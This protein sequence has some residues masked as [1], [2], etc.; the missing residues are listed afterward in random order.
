[1]LFTDIERSTQML[2][3]LGNE[4]YGL[5]LADHRR[6]CREAFERFGG[7]EVDTQG[8]SFFVVFE[9]AVDAAAAA[10]HAQAALGV[11]A[12]RVR[13]GLHTGNPVVSD[14]MYVG[15]DVHRAARIAAAAHGC[16]IVVSAAS[17]AELAGDPRL[18]SLGMHSLKDF[19]EPIEL[20]QLGPGD[21]PPLRSIAPTNLPTPVSAFIGRELEL[22]DAE[23]IRQTSRLLTIVGA[24]GSGK[25]RFAI[26]LARRTAGSFPGGT[27]FVSLSA[28]TD[29]ALVLPA[30]AAA[31]GIDDVGESPIDAIARRSRT[32]PTAIVLDNLEQLTEAG[33]D[34][35]RL[36]AAV[37]SVSILATSRN[38]LFVTGEQ[39]FELDVLTPADAV[40]LFLER[41]KD[42]G[43][44]IDAS[45][46]IVPQLCA[47]VDHLP[48][49]IELIAARA[50]IM[51]L[52]QMLS[53]L[54]NPL[55]IESRLRDV[56]ARHRTLRTTLMWSHS[57]LS[58]VERAVFASLSVFADG[59][60]IEAAEAVCECD[61]DVIQALV[62]HSLARVRFSV[63]GQ[64]RSWMLE[65]VRMFATE[66]LD[67]DR[68]EIL[69]ERLTAYTLGLL[70]IWSPQLNASEQAAACAWFDAELADLRA[71]AHRLIERNDPRAGRYVFNL[72][73]YLWR[74]GRT[75]EENR[76]IARALTV[77]RMPDRDRALLHREASA[78]ALT[79]GDLATSQDH[80]ERALALIEPLEER[81]LRLQLLSASGE[82]FML[83]GEADVAR[84]VWGRCRAEALDHGEH[85]A[86]AIIEWHYGTLAASEQAWDD[87]A[88]NFEA[89]RSFHRSI[90]DSI[91]VAWLSG[92]L[93]WVHANRNDDASARRELLS[94]FETYE[95]VGLSPGLHSA[96]L[97][98]AELLRRRSPV[99]AAEAVAWFDR[100]R[101]DGL[102]V[103]FADVE[104]FDELR[105][106]LG[107]IPA[108]PSGDAVECAAWA[109]RHVAD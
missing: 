56:P 82:L 33:A 88:A 67:E 86:A 78:A 93:G 109:I 36:V 74:R 23:S 105:A 68:A 3:V 70:E 5:A 25:T 15:L 75:D 12:V 29:A 1:M 104:K 39:V 16:Q 101:T 32:V 24:G 85:R 63:D 71:T 60:T 10:V 76:L 73:R 91:V 41:A 8:D 9:R 11:T 37:A 61:V 90:G 100:L 19:E 58:D 80:V 45:S 64:S 103:D 62:E 31:M 66:Q 72:G 2:E 22:V 99:E 77:S 52:P 27:W 94:A 57:L 6:I 95:R 54:T 28:T 35:A 87:A 4:K 79:A 48:L 65:L 43:R 107:P 49:A 13:M 96:V 53:T 92:L 55:D 51:P 102:E 89:S 108:R 84:E 30:I 34:I 98:L 7:T 20:F 21:H 50:R 42:S 17:A 59:W 44:T 83:R 46:E 40:A 106:A 97:G 14:G 47:R 81:Q 26:E 38:P 18:L 69:R